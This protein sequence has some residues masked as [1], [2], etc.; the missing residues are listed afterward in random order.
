LT[1]TGRPYIRACPVVPFGERVRRWNVL[2]CLLSR[3]SL[4]LGKRAARKLLS[5]PRGKQLIASHSRPSIHLRRGASRAEANRGRSPESTKGEYVK[6][7][8][9]GAPARHSP[10]LGPGCRVDRSGVSENLAKV[11]PVLRHPD[12]TAAQAAVARTAGQLAD[13]SR[14]DPGDDLISR[15]SSS[16]QRHRGTRI[17]GATSERGCY[18]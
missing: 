17:A 5:R 14:H 3:T 13:G 1:R 10:L 4:T 2:S 8:V 12:L 16:G 6:Y 7:V 11:S 9:G 15:C 18:S